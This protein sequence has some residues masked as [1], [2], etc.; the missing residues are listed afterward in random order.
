MVQYTQL[1]ADPRKMAAL[2]LCGISKAKVKMLYPRASAHM[3]QYKS[4]VAAQWQ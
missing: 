2:L 3:Q 4:S 1:S